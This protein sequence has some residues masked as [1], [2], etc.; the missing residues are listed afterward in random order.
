MA[1]RLCNMMK[2]VKAGKTEGAQPLL[3]KVHRLTGNW[4]EAQRTLEAALQK[5][6]AVYGR[7][8]LRKFF[9]HQV[10]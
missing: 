1:E 5:S 4:N 10:S 6:E 9:C 2:N 3:G 8:H 7:N